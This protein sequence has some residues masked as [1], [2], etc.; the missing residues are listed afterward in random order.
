MFETI[1]H[2]AWVSDEE[3]Y[4]HDDLVEPKILNMRDRGLTDAIFTVIPDSQWFV[5]QRQWLNATAALE[6]IEFINQF[7]PHYAEIIN[8]A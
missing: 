2:V 1:T 3:A 6:W 4:S 7:D 8:P 5:V